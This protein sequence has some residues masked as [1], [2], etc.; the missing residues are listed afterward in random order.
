MKREKQM[1]SVSFSGQVNCVCKRNCA[2][3]I[4]IVRQKEIFDQYNAF[5][6]WNQ[7]TTFLRE[8]VVRKK[9]DKEDVNPTIQLKK[10]TSSFSCFFSDDQGVKHRVCIW[11]VTKLL[12]IDRSKLFK[13]IDSTAKNPSAADRRGQYRSRPEDKQFVMDFIKKIPQY[14]SKWNRTQSSTKYIH[15][16]LS[17]KKL[18][19][20]YK[21]SCSDQQRKAMSFGYFTKKFKT[22]D[23]A[24]TKHRTQKCWK[25]HELHS[26]TKKLIYSAEMKKK[27]NEKEKSHLD[28]AKQV[29]NSFQDEILIAQSAFENTEIFTFGLGRPFILPSAAIDHTKRH[30]FLHEMCVFDEV[31]Q[32]G[33]IYAWPESVASKGSAE[34][35]SCIVH[36]LRAT[37]SSNTKHLILFCDPNHGQNRNMKLSLMLQQFLHTWKHPDLKSIKQIFFF[38]GHGYNNCDRCFERIMTKKSLQNIFFPVA[39]Y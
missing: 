5:K 27:L 32:I 21:E 17:I 33:Y 24:F 13:A 12:Q 1:K 3:Q 25:C 23:I 7:K 8:L 37:L 38:H 39:S 11:F 20:K 18:Y 16:D 4:D 14:E 15:P 28:L 29:V 36:H 2:T 19:D 31:R 10:K 9:R 26:E 30:F 34:I 22:F 6:S 35:A